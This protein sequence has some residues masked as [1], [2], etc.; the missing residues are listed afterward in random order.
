MSRAPGC[1]ITSLV[2]AGDIGAGQAI[3]L[4]P[5]GVACSI[6]SA[7]WRLSFAASAAF[8]SRLR[9][10]RDSNAAA[11]TVAAWE[12]QPPGQTTT[13][14]TSSSSSSLSALTQLPKQMQS[15][16]QAQAQALL[17]P[18]PPPRAAHPTL[19]RASSVPAR[20]RPGSW[21]T[22]RMSLMLAAVV[23]AVSLAAVLFTDSPVSVLTGVI[24]LVLVVLVVVWLA[25]RLVM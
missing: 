12:G 15:Q 20:R 13:T 24:V 4:L 17:S 21:C 23:S 7:L 2:P 8:V 5:A 3:T 11:T 9:K 16:S 19:S 18:T 22:F 14:T 6:Y 10:R 1:V 25:A